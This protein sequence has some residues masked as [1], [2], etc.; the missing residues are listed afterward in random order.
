MIA[1][2][3]F[4]GA[5]AI[6]P[7]VAAGAGGSLEMLAGPGDGLSNAGWGIDYANQIN[8]ATGLPNGVGGVAGGAWSTPGL[9][10]N[11]L[12]N[13]LP[14]S[15]ITNIGDV[16]NGAEPTFLN[17]VPDWTLPN[18]D[19]Q[20]PV[21]TT[22]KV[23]VP[24]ADL[25]PPNPSGPGGP[26]IPPGGPGGGGGNPNAPG[27]NFDPF[28]TLLTLAD[29][30]NKWAMGNNVRDTMS[31]WADKA[32]G[33]SGEFENTLLN[34]YTN[35]AAYYAGPE[36]TSLRDIVSKRSNRT[37]ANIGGLT[38]PTV[39][40]YVTTKALVENMNNYRT[41][42]TGAANVGRAAT[43]EAIRGMGEALKGQQQA[44]S[45]YTPATFNAGNSGSNN[46]LQTVNNTVGTVKN[47]WDWGNQA[48]NWAKGIF[49]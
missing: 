23:A 24:P 44:A 16:Y 45:W 42:L 13:G 31:A 20:T 2:N 5:G 36:F 14:T 21:D 6:A 12:P 8:P 48:W 7:G 10:T 11:A 25:P 39:P 4:A 29:M 22:P 34:T 49:G 43:G 17:D 37:A 40:D 27:G 47:F 30:Y 18:P 26:P 38:N 32:Y 33:K 1:P 9:T 28:N 15:A 35:P 3:A 46:P 19:M 41:G